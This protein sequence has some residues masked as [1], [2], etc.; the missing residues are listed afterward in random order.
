[1]KKIKSISVIVA[2]LI[3]MVLANQSFIV[4][5]ATKSNVDIFNGT[6]TANAWS[7]A[8]SINSNKI[9]GTMDVSKLSGNGDFYIEYTGEQDGIQLILQSWLGGKS[10]QTVSPNEVGIAEDNN[11]YAKFNANTIKEVY[12][13]LENLCILH[14][15]STV[16]EIT[17]KSIKYIDSSANSSEDNKHEEDMNELGEQTFLPTEENVKTIGRTF[18]YKDS[19]WLAQSASG[20]EYSFTGTKGSVTILGD[21]VATSS[22]GQNSYA[23]VAVYVNNEK[24]VDELIT[25][26]E[27]TFD[28][29]KSDEAQDVNV[30]IVKLS[31]SANSTVGVKDI[32]VISK[33]GIKK[34]EKKQHSIEFIGDS[35]TCG[36]GVD[37]ESTTASFSTATENATKT[38]AYKTAKNLDADYSMVSFSGYGIISGYTGTGEKNTT[39]ILPKYYDKVGFSYGY[40]NSEVEVASVDWDF[41]KSQPDVVVINLGTNDSSYCKSDESKKA[42][43]VEG[44][45]EFLKQVRAKNPNAQI[46][47][48]LGMMGDDLYT[49]I[50]SAVEQYTSAT[51]DLKVSSMKFDVQ[52]YS[53]GFAVDYHPT[54]KT[55]EKAAKKLTEKIKTIMNW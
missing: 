29:F 42:E 18:E 45:V 25:E 26:D 40:F 46:L 22:W 11:Y 36:Y 30:K 33:D 47:C 10:W 7:T 17:V 53:D 41:N 16:G 2:T 21:N 20:I 4:S 28:I 38:Y 15:W 49:S 6:A 24:V 48:T 54:E 39:S 3:F 5:A 8:V 43:F 27:K 34:A 44:Y 51:S 52:S 14:V 1:M 37:L 35:I 50:E 9:G 23:R 13:D 31:E 19:L 55:H 12:G 32:K